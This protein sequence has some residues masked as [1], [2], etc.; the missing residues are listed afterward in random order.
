MPPSDTRTNLRSSEFAID[1]ASDVLPTPG[2]PGEAEDRPLHRRVELPHREIF[3]DA[4]LHLLESRVVGV[5]HALGPD[6]VDDFVGALRPG[7]RNQPVE[8]RARDRVFGGRD[9]HLRQAIELALGLLLYGVRHAGRLD[10]LAQL[11]DFLGLI[12]ALAQLLLNRLHLLAQEVFALVLA[13]LRLDLRLDLRAQLQHF[14]FLDQQA[15][16]QIEA[17]AHVDGFEHFLLHLRAQRGQARRDEVGEPARL[18][19]VHRQR[20]QIVGQQRRQRDHMLEVGL[21]VPL[22]RV[23][24]EPIFVAHD[25]VRRR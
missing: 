18:G 8:I 10:L 25:V 11:F 6:E 5:E 24:L 15:V 22:Q 13:D 19:D 3:Q 16:Q 2:G 21:D 17:R 9:R 4:I 12:V 1:L 20:L 7:Q 14:G 23:D